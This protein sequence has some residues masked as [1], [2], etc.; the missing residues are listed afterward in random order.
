MAKKTLVDAIRAAVQME[1]V[2]VDPTLSAEEKQKQ[3]NEQLAI[4]S[5]SNLLE[6]GAIGDEGIELRHEAEQILGEAGINP[7]EYRREN[8]LAGVR[9]TAAI[10]PGQAVRMIEQPDETL[11]EAEG[12]TQQ[13]TE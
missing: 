3:V 11:E 13:P 1:S 10:Q 2:K 4:V 5:D 6:L 8:A 7:R 9:A 12:A